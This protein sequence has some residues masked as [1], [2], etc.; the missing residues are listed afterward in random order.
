MA[1][2]IRNMYDVFGNRIND[3][4]KE[5]V[6]DILDRIN[7]DEYLDNRD[8]FYELLLQDIN[9]SYFIYDEYQW[10]MM[11]QYQNP[12]DAN[13]NEAF[14]LFVG[15]MVELIENIIDDMTEEE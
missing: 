6:D 3:D 14:D 8:N 9:D 15:D 4:F 2:Y 12:Q 11:M 7:F 13:F 1:K 5:L 10:A